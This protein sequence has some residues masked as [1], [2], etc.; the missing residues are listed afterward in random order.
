M[1]TPRIKQAIGEVA[2]RGLVVHLSLSYVPDPQYPNII[3]IFVEV[4]V[5]WPCNEGYTTSMS[6]EIELESSDEDNEQAILDL[7][8]D[9]G[10]RFRIDEERPW[11]QN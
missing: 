7:L 3:S 1:L 6:H 8:S 11:E 5:D 10:S 9:I 2:E 4:C